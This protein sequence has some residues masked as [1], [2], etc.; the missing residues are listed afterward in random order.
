L[1]KWEKYEREYHGD[2]F[3]RKILASTLWEML[4]KLVLFGKTNHNPMFVFELNSQQLTF[5]L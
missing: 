4:L 1:A 2:V 5:S 3:T